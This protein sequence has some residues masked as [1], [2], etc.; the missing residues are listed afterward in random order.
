VRLSIYDIRGK[1]IRT[2]VNEKKVAG[3]Y[4]VQFEGSDLPAGIYLVRLQA[5]EQVE[6]AKM[7]VM[8]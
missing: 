4:I 8:R 2:L 5:G 3:E 1:E 7:I 6:T